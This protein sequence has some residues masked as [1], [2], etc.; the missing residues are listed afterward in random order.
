MGAIGLR[1]R[2]F[3]VLIFVVMAVSGCVSSREYKSMLSEFDGL[4]DEVLT[5]REELGRKTAE[6]ASLKDEITALERDRD[7]LAEKERK[8]RNDNSDL[9]YMIEANKLELTRDLIKIKSELDESGLSIKRLEDD[10]YSKNSKI[11]ELEERLENLSEKRKVAIEKRKE[12]VEKL[13]DTY[14]ELVYELKEEIEKGRIEVTS[15][16]DKLS[17]SMVDRILFSSG[18][19][20]IK[21]DGKK[22]LDRVAGILKKT[23]D[24]QIRIEGHTD[25]VPIGPDLAKK[26]PTNW[27]LST[28]RASNVVRYL[29]ETAG[30]VPRLLSASGYGEHMPV[31]S[32]ETEEG[33]AKNR[34][35]EIVLIPFDTETDAPEEPEGS[36]E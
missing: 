18:S 11:A 24:R 21:E 17:L 26:Y 33:R 25:N 1:T 7:E 3:V 27:E 5:L 15:L 2:I 35:I 36:S 8:L 20:R 22:V 31:A 30:I 4:K 12:A 23:T 19:T 32:N 14:N 29:Q 34:R 9:K 6:N 28:A 13:K 16:K 10:L